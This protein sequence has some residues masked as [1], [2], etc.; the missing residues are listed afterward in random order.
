MHVYYLQPIGQRHHKPYLEKHGKVPF[1]RVAP[2]NQ[3][4]L[5]SFFEK[6]PRRS[7]DGL[8]I[9]AQC[10][11]DP[12]PIDPTTKDEKETTESATIFDPMQQDQTRE[13]QECK[14]EQQQHHSQQQEHQQE[15][16]QQKQ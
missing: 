9:G 16:E 11:S 12:D 6:Q 4:T 14:L 8:Q 3:N 2:S 5:G 10:S 1:K 15:L 7:E 13:Q